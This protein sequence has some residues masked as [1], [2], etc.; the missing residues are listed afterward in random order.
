MMQAHRQLSSRPLDA[1][2][3]GQR[4]A[5]RLTVNPFRVNPQE[6]VDASRRPFL[7]HARDVETPRDGKT[8]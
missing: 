3:C 1:V 2:I 4:A 8:T 5:R 7:T 6:L